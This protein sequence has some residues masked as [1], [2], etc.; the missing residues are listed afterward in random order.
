MPKKIAII[1]YGAWGKALRQLLEDTKQETA[2][3][4][5]GD[6]LKDIHDSYDAV[7]LSI[8]VAAYEEILRELQQTYHHAST[9]KLCIIVAKGMTKDGLLP[10]FVVQKYLP[11]VNF[12]V[13]SGPNF[14]H[15][16][17]QRQ[18]TATLLSSQKSNIIDAYID[19]F[20]TH[21]CRPYFHDDPLAI[22]YL[23]ALKNIYAIGAGMIEGKKLGMNARASYI[24]RSIAEMAHILRAHHL[25][26]NTA[27]GLAG[28]GDL[29]LTTSSSQSRNMAFGI[30]IGQN[31]PIEQALKESK[32]VVEGFYA[33][34]PMYEKQ[35][36][37]A[38]IPVLHMISH[39]LHGEIT[40]DDALQY[41]FSRPLKKE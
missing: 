9:L 26:E 17:C 29:I 3:Y 37:I 28:M 11:H 21:Y 35:K 8:P 7:I 14:A 12:A 6:S 1:G 25:D 22:Q 4:V 2:I 10:S 20:S 5:R 36:N 40:F 27:Y 18:H 15:E 33:A 31:I 13:L 23:G 32:G 16:V 38:D 24:T 34:K 19:A 30:K 41:V 39:I